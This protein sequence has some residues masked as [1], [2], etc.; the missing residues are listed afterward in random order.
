MSL[1]ITMV[2]EIFGGNVNIGFYEVFSFFDFWYRKTS[3]R[4][5]VLNP[6]KIF[7]IEIFI[8]KK[9]SIII[10]IKKN[11]LKMYR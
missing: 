7:F 1:I 3:V 8:T 2:V 4:A 10:M 9:F 5:T 6:L 11:T